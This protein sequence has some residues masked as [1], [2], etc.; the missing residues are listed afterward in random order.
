MGISADQ[1]ELGA[2]AETFGRL[3][4]IALITGNGLTGTGGATAIALNLDA[5]PGLEFNGA[6]VRA[7][8]GAGMARDGTGLKVDQAAG[9]TWT[10]VHDFSGAPS[11]SLPTPTLAAHAATKSYVD[12]IASGLDVKKSVRATTIAALPACTY[13]NGTS[14]VDATLTADANGALAAQD[15]VTLIA[16]ERFL[17]KNQ[18]AGLQN[19]IYVVT[20]V[21]NAGAPFILTRAKDADQAAEVSGG[22]FAFVEEGTSFADCGFVLTVDGT[23]TM[24]TTALAFSQFSSN[25]TIQAGAGLTK[26]GNTVDIVNSDGSLTVDADAISVKIS[27]NKGISLDGGS[28]LQLNAPGNGIALDGGGV[29]Q[30]TLDG[31]SL[32]KSATGVKV[33]DLGVATAQLAS[34]AVTLV[35]FGARVKA[36]DEQTGGAGTAYNLVNR[37]VSANHRHVKVFRNG[38]RAKMMAASPVGKDEYTVTDN[39]TN[40]IITF[41]TAP[42]TDRLTFD[43]MY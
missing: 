33:A 23:V 31:T 5:D 18:A 8:V 27:A 4:R 14:G 40:T 41:G 25:G 38:V 19:G 36:D 20:Q 11:V 30:L 2:G 35:K 3:L 26:T 37:I 42:N 43:Y 13:A 12:D 10:G 24:G 32:S 29:L 34:D 9:F 16:T 21:G 28:G 6:A 7:K 17:V 22:L 1:I 39:G 15:G